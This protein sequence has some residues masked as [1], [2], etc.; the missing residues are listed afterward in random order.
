MWDGTDQ[1][2]QDM[3]NVLICG[4]PRSGTSFLAGVLEKA[5]YDIGKRAKQANGVR[6][7]MGEEDRN[8]DG[9]VLELNFA[10]FR[11]MDAE[12]LRPD[13]YNPAWILE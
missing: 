1:D 10:A 12:P 9:R 3:R 11:R 2:G 7:D 13:A 5:G 8:E 6:T 4:N